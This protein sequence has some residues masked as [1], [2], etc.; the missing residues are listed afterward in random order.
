MDCSTMFLSTW[1]V[2]LHWVLLALNSQPGCWDFDNGAIS[3]IDDFLTDHSLLLNFL[4]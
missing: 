4:T 1:L 3:K 2:D